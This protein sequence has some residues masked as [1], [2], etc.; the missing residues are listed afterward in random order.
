MTLTEDATAIMA[1]LTTVKSELEMLEKGNK[2]ASA[3]AR[4][5][6]QNAKVASHILRKKITAFHSAMPVRARVVRSVSPPEQT[7]IPEVEAVVAT[8][9]TPKRVRKAKSETKVKKTTQ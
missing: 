9:V 5:G 1:H 6:L 4:K 8:K 7:E 2:S 3:R